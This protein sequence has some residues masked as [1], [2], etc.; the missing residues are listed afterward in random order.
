MTDDAKSESYYVYAYVRAVTSKNGEAGTPYYIGK[1]KGGRARAE[2]KTVRVPKDRSRIVMI[3]EN[4]I[5]TEALELEI[6][7]IAKYGRIDS[8]TGIL[9]N[10]TN[11]GEGT[12]GLV[13]TP[14]ARARHSAAKKKYYEDPEARA[15]NSETQKKYFEDPEARARNSEAHTQE[16]RARM[17]VAMKKRH[18]DPEAK[19]RH[20]A[21]H[22]TQEV[23]SRMSDAKKKYYEDPEARARHSAATKKYYE[24][25][26]ARAKTSAASKKAWIARKAKN[27]SSSATLP[28]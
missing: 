6:S 5:E 18:E 15:R 21:S 9:R 25:P 12:S 14:E 17:S 19:A 16:V 26:E 8:G 7:E 28:I 13:H 4:L 1:G 23:R 3:R 27:Q 24:D 22:N 10:L 20:F 2:H 11:G